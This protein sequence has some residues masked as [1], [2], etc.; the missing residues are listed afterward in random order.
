MTNFNL[1]NTYFG[2]TSNL[3]PLQAGK[4]E[5]SLDMLIRYD[6][7]VLTKK[8]Y[9]YQLLL[10]GCTPAIEENYSYYSSRTGEMTKPKTLYKLTYSDESFHEINKT[11]YNYAQLLIE[12]NYI[13]ETIA[14]EYIAEE[15]R[16]NE[17]IKRLEQ[18]R[19]QKERAE[20]EKQR[21]QQEK[22]ELEERREKIRIWTEKGQS[23]MT[24]EIENL[25]KNTIKNHFVEYEVD[26]PEEDKEK[27]INEFIQSFPQKLGNQSFVISNLQY[28]L[29]REEERNYFHPMNI[30]AEVLMN[31]FNISTDDHNRT[32][33]AKV[34]AVH[35]NREYK[36][37]NYT[38]KEQQEFYIF[39]NQSKQF[40]LK[41]GEKIKLNGLTCFISK[42]DSDL[43][44][45]TEA[46][47]GLLLG[48]PKATKK[49]A[50]ETSKQ[51]IEKAG[52]RL[53]SLIQNSINRYG[54][55]PLYKETQTA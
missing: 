23:L 32:I 40:E 45:I 11:L 44:A 30:E 47:T 25:I 16:Q 13:N 27:F 50:I 35:E 3:K 18:E 2:F 55:S 31:I 4:V 1:K 37:G 9:I 7:K 17:E 49:E 52:E 8:E 54:I 53:E 19:I 10:K 12:N 5:K 21:Q 29:E 6:G 48:S 24:N 15:Q 14:A 26:A 43:W 39:N 28:H 41:Q 51:G 36:G 46:R 22:K 38:P 34:K 33:T 20:K 42:N